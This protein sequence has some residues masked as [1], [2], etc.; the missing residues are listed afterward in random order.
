MWALK[1][2][3]VDAGSISSIRATHTRNSYGPPVPIFAYIYMSFNSD[4]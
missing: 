2:R 1:R 3:A 4:R